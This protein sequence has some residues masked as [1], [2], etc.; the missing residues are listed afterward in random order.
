[1]KLI[2][3]IAVVAAAATSAQAAEL[4][5]GAATAAPHV[6]AFDTPS[7]TTEASFFAYPGI[8]GGVRVAVGDVNGDHVPDYVTAPSDGG[9]TNVK[10]FSGTNLAEVRS[11]LAYAGSNAGVFV[12]AG[13]VNHDGVAD[14]VTGLG[15]GPAGGHVKTFDGVTGAEIKSFFA[16]PGF[17]GA[18]RVA[19]GDLDGDGFADIVTGAGPGGGPHVKVF[20][21]ASGAEL[22]SFFAFG[23]SFTGGVSVS[24]GTWAG[25]NAIFVG[26]GAGGGP[27][28]KAFRMSDLT[29]LAS[30]FAFDAGFTGG[31][32]VAWGD[33]DGH[34]ALYVATASG[35]AQVRVFDAVAGRNLGAMIGS[36]QPYAGFTGGVEIA[37]VAPPS[38]GGVPEP[39]TWAMML[40]GFGLAGAALRTRRRFRGITA[41]P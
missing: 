37:A 18:V 17:A 4:V 30:F 22:R 26:A 24:A 10:V 34:A 5:T 33:Y 7:L 11:F 9:A 27:H 28:V 14:I 2:I 21:G 32:N 25:E 35:D 41:R 8:A 12:A 36:F 3:A 13:D 16:Y 6:K 38:N 15:A 29:E 19:A 31:V 39:T 23:P 20:S 40:G 1:M